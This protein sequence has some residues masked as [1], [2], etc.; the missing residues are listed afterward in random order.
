ML[1]L[2]DSRYFS[3]TFYTTTPSTTALVSI[4]GG[5]GI[6]LIQAYK[7]ETCFQK[8]YSNSSLLDLCVNMFSNSSFLNLRVSMFFQT[9]HF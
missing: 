8:R 9:V 4:S 5:T 3:L 2:P 7:P 1:G 6:E